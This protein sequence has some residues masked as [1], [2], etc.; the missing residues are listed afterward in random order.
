MSQNPEAQAKLEKLWETLPAEI[1]SRATA[2]KLAPKYIDAKSKGLEAMYAVEPGLYKG[3]SGSAKKAALRARV[4]TLSNSLKSAVG[5]QLGKDGTIARLD[6]SDGD[7]DNVDID[8]ILRQN[9]SRMRNIKIDLGRWYQFKRVRKFKA[10]LTE[11]IPNWFRQKKRSAYDKLGGV[12]KLA[13]VGALAA[14][15]VGG[16]VYYNGGWEQMTQMAKNAGGSTV[17]FFTGIPGNISDAFEGFM[18]G[19]PTVT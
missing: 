6:L 1:E 11:D 9:N 12:A 14:A 10:M 13:G 17:D 7:Y 19:S 16:L 5:D 15:S 2:I 4:E 8:T 18:P 3:L